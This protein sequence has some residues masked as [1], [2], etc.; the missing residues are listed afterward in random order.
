MLQALKLMFE[1]QAGVEQFDLIQTF[2]A[3]KQEEGKS[4]SSYVLKMK[5]YVKK[6]EHLGY[7]LP[8]D[9]SVGL[10]MKGLTSDFAEF[11][12]NYNMHNMGKI[13]GGRIQKANK[14]SLNAKGKDKG[15]G[16]GNGKSYIPKPKKSKPSAKEHPTK[17]DTC[18]H[19]KE[20]GHWKRN[21]LVYLAELVMKKKQVGTVS[22][23]GPS[24]AEKGNM[25]DELHKEV[26]KASTSKGAESLI[27][28]AI[29][30]ESENESS[31]DSEALIMEGRNDEHSRNEMATYCDFTACDVP[32][33]DGTLDPIACTKW[34]SAV[35]GAFR[36]SCCKEKN[37]L[38]SPQ[39]SFVIV[40]KCGGKEKFV[41]REEFQTLTQTN[42]TV[43]EM[44]KKFNN[45][46]CYCPEYHG[47]EKLKVEKFQRMLRD[48]IQEV[49]SPFKCT[50]LE[51]L[52]SRA[53]LREADLL[54]KN[55]KET[56]R[57]LDF[58]DRDAKK[59]K[60]DQGRRSGGTQIKT[61]CEKC[62]KTYLGVYRA[63]FTGCYKCGALNHM[64]KD[65]KKPM[66]LCYNFNQLGNKSNKCTNPKAIEAKP[67][68]SIKEEKM[69]KTGISTP[70]AR[71][72]I[73]ATEDDKVVRYV[74]TG[75]IL[76]NSI[77]ARMLYDSGGSVSFVSFEFSKNLSTPP[78]KLPFP[79]E[80]EIAGN[81]IVVVSKVY[82]DV[83]I[84]I[85]DSVFK[86]DLIPI[87]LG[88]FDIV[89]GMNWLDR[90]NANILC[91]QKLVRVVNPLGREI[92]IY[93]DKKK[94]EFRLCS[95]MKARKYLS[96][97]CQA[98]MAHVIDTRCEKKS[99]TDVLI[100]NEFLNVFPEDLT[101]I[102]PKRQVEFRI[103]LI[104]R[105]TPI[106]KTSYRLAPS[107]WGAP[108]LFVKKKDG[109]MRMCIDY[110]ELNKVTVK[111]V[112]PLPRIDDLFDQLQGTEDMVI[113]SDA[114]YSGLRCVLMQRGKAAQ[115]EALKEENWKSER[116]TSYIPYFK[117]DSR[118]IKTQ[119]GRIYIPFR[120]NFKELLLEKA[121]K[122]KYS[123]HPG[124]TKMYLD[125]K[126]NY[127]WPGMKRDCVKYVKKC[128]TCLKVKVEHQKP[129]GKIQPLDIPVWKWEK[130]TMDFVTKLPR[131]TKKHDAIWVIVDR[132]TKSAHFIPIR[133]GMPVYKL[134][135]FYV[136]EIVARHGDI[137]TAYPTN[138]YGVLGNTA[139]DMACYKS[140]CNTTYAINKYDVFLPWSIQ[141][142]RILEYGL[143]LPYTPQHNDVSERRN[144]TLLDMVRSMMNLTTLPLSFWDYT[145]ESA[146]CILNMVPTKKVDKTPYELCYEKVPNLSYLKIWGCVAL[147]K[148]DTPEKF[149]QRSVKY[150]E[151]L[152]KNL[153]S[154]EVIRRA[155]E[156]EEIQDEDTSPSEHTSEIPIE[157]EGFKPPQEEVVPIRRVDY[158]E[159]F[160]PVAD[161]RAIEILIAIAAF[162]D[163]ETCL[164]RIMSYL[165]K[166][167]A[168]KDLGEAAFILGIKIYRDR[169]KRL[170]RLSESAYM[171][172]IL[173]M[174]KMENSKRGNI[175]MQ[176]RF[177]LNKTQGAST[178]EE[179]KRMQNVPY[180]SAVGSIMYAVECTR[181]DVTFAQNITSHFQ[182]N[183]EE[184]HWTDVKIILKYL[185]NTK[186]MF[187][188][189]G[190]N[191]K[192][193]LRVD[194][195]CNAGFE[196][197]RD[198]IKSQTRYVFILNG[199]TVH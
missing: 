195:Y 6:L 63:N 90:Y 52:L 125:L 181:P 42:E 152:E 57:K 103:D 24:G 78:Y 5:G 147:V 145:L 133:E 178:P 48:D 148:R 184:P 144:H 140:K 162:Y 55:N 111:N 23:S 102:P 109:S 94:G 132:L 33:F 14:K 9:L 168:M 37:K 45:L 110:R 66:I 74:V 179:V 68:K 99:V 70:T 49:I 141:G 194:C 79:L 25:V 159:T 32:K 88:A 44:W 83:E 161:I 21:C 73:M 182:R 116:I 113:Y 108:I 137:N 153:I 19:Y 199:G 39:T 169:T 2:H 156:L 35:E 15:K 59:P 84:E 196:T 128:L 107:P 117:D 4:V 197:D 92:I 13:I 187:L 185:R 82:R 134:S 112:Y 65:C 138:V 22:S 165:G 120:S 61:P 85:D 56:K 50:T 150:A 105:A 191:P 60:Q 28:D 53:R 118:G 17:D 158:E 154:Q 180:A 166:C 101:G 155:V 143:T 131:T 183:L 129:Y 119:Q 46:I 123:I 170:I 87:V 104:P 20:V 81:E 86:N 127:W 67:L 164:Q 126:R 54:R 16:K 71:A 176:E 136:N 160:S 3:C 34:L 80:V 186:D 64:S 121:H 91:S 96:H 75:T 69:E 76:V 188:V 171:N 36:T 189:F 100:V 93:G 124:D 77:P 11:I 98:F 149:Q 130:I 97:G 7:M 31:S 175:L 157:V 58:V 40:L 174:F 12:R 190:G 30:D 192:A 10:I 193:E 163:Y 26:R 142:A 139:T 38:T 62:H 115:L 172:K 95:M 106:A 135:K 47:N 122:S 51:D 167:F 8:Q 72:Y 198:D 18:H 146:T 173:K 177:D 29:R 43:N 1:K 27:G 41:K 114:S 89:I 151:F